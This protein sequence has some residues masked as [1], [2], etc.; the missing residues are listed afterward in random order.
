MVNTFS[1]NPMVLIHI[2][3]LVQTVFV[4]FQLILPDEF[5]P[6]DKSS[7]L[8][9]NIIKGLG[10]GTLIVLGLI[11][12]DSALLWLF[13]NWSMAD[14]LFQLPSVIIL[15]Y[16]G[17]A[18]IIVPLFSK[19]NLL[20]IIFC[21]AAVT[22]VLVFLHWWI[23]S[24]AVMGP[25]LEGGLPILIGVLIGAYV[26]VFLLKNKQKEEGIKNWRKNFWDIRKQ[27]H[28]GFSR[29]L[30]FIFWVLAVVQSMLAFYGYSILTLG[31]S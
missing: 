14:W 15:L 2:C 5:S 25:V 7:G 27:L 9:V 4:A 17:L 11:F 22:T 20:D 1:F 26:P 23:P 24:H 18:Y 16:L 13:G 21:G 31:A 30:H 6:E 8:I 19:G 12:L 3:A 10:W 28:Q 29:T